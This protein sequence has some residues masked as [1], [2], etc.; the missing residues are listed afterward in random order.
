MRW[1]DAGLMSAPGKVGEW[2]IFRWVPAFA[3]MTKGA[4]GDCAALKSERR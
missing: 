4:A 1:V 2:L 3:G